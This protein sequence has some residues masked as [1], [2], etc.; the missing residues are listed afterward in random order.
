MSIAT[1]HM[2]ANTVLGNANDGATPVARTGNSISGIDTDAD[3]AA[4]DEVVREPVVTTTVFNISSTEIV[5]VDAV[6]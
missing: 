6:R 3:A 1:L 5:L 2:A 4:L